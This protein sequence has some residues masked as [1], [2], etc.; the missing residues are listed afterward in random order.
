MNRYKN[1]GNREFQEAD[2]SNDPKH[3]RRR[4]KH[5]RGTEK[6][7]KSEHRSKEKVVK[8][9]VA[10]LCRERRKSKTPGR[11]RNNIQNFEENRSKS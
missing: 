3:E 7:A 11:H 6:K 9:L 2:H 5:P 8:E 4:D 1:R 10:E